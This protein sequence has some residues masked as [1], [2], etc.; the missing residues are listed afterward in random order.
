MKNNI[1]TTGIL[2]LALG[3]GLGMAA[4]AQA[5][6]PQIY[7]N[8]QVLQTEVSPVQQNGRVL[9]PMRNIFENLGATVN[10]NDLNQSITATKG[11]TV[12][13]MAMGSRNATVNG[14]PYKLDVPAKAYYGRTLVPLRFVSEAMG[15]KVNYNANTRVVMIAGKGYSGGND[16]SGGNSQVAGVRQISIPAESVIPVTLDQELS[17]A[18]AY[19]GQTFSASVVSDRPGDSEFPQ[20]TKI[21]GRVSQVQKKTGGEP[22]VLELQFTGARLPNNSQ[23]NLNGSL[24]SMDN[25]SVKTVGGRVVAQGGKGKNDSLKVL[26][27]GAGAG[28]VIGKLLK[29]NSAVTALLGAAGGYLYNKSKGDK[30]AEARL[31]AG[32]KFGVRLNNGVSYRDTTGYASE[33]ANYVRL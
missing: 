32:S 18:N 10:Y 23:V 31:A 13:R 22:G 16:M 19:V 21:L 33:R 25:D 24:I 14:L 30:G 6:A 29:K 27:V 7:L 3:A 20:G 4:Q 12:V 28:F 1:Q 8:N 15:A 26:G 9:V 2:T 11:D 5:P 17:S